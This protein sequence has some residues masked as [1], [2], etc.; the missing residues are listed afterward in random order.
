MLTPFRN[1]IRRNGKLLCSL[2]DVNRLTTVKT[3]IP[4][5][6]T[7][8]DRQLYHKVVVRMMSSNESN[9]NENDKNDNDTTNVDNN[10]GD[11]QEVYENIIHDLMKRLRCKRKLAGRI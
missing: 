3:S 1:L 5:L 8:H 11:K 6:L 2:N 4:I 10:N 7:L 9:K